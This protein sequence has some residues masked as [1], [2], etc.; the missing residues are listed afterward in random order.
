[1]QPL[2]YI[3]KNGIT[4]GPYTAKGVQTI[5]I[6]PGC[7]FSTNINKNAL[8]PYTDGI[9]EFNDPGE[10]NRQYYLAKEGRVFAIHPY[11]ALERELKQKSN[12]ALYDGIAP[13][14]LLQKAEFVWTQGMDKWEPVRFFPELNALMQ[15]NVTDGLPPIPHKPPVALPPLP[16]AAPGA[17]ARRTY[18]DGSKSA[19]T[20][21]LMWEYALNCVAKKYACF[22]GRAGRVE[23]WSFVLFSFLLGIALSLATGGQP[24]AITPYDISDFIP[25]FSRVNAA[26][27]LVSLAL[28]LP[29]LA[30]AVRRLHDTNRSGWWLLIGLVPVAGVIVLLV[31]LIQ[32]GT[33]VDNRY[34]AAPEHS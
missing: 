10:A 27:S 12:L 20:F 4:S 8:K 6:E 5:G 34:G 28:L 30:V 14:S 24:F 19:V 21:K 2:F 3:H 17:N 29:S 16:G 22:T 18:S 25:Y 1:M 9:I 7:F 33:L 11:E 32:K 13:K 15:N 26:S 23:Y 31:F